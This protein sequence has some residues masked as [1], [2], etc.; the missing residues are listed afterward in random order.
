[1]LFFNTT[2]C[3]CLFH[4]IS[5]IKIK[6]VYVFIVFFWGFTISQA[7]AQE[8]ENGSRATNSEPGKEIICQ[9]ES[10]NQCILNEN[11]VTVH[12]LP[13][14]SMDVS[15]CLIKNN[16]GKYSTDE[17][18]LL[19]KGKDLPVESKKLYTTNSVETNISEVE[20]TD[21]SRDFTQPNHISSAI[22]KEYLTYISEPIENHQSVES[23]ERTL[24]D[25]DESRFIKFSSEDDS[26]LEKNKNENH[27][28]LMHKDEEDESEIYF[29]SKSRSLNSPEEI[30]G[31]KQEVFYD[32]RDTKSDLKRRTKVRR[33]FLTDCVLPDIIPDRI[34]EISSLICSPESNSTRDSD[35]RSFA[36]AL[37]SKDHRENYEKVSKKVK[38]YVQPVKHLLLSISSKLETLDEHSMLIKKLFLINDVIERTLID[39]QEDLSN[40]KFLLKSRNF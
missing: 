25:I 30:Y 20:S 18:I 19:A 14:N 32:Q 33:S 35:K 38:K 13:E 5:M 40:V 34:I 6:Y 22:Q 24:L 23:D 39:I 1:M 16:G 3:T 12:S 10:L 37:N 7:Y 17:C 36:E 26:Y 21:S 15:R 27:E 29:G 28:Y 4:I 9:P 31:P 2:A 8:D 11:Q